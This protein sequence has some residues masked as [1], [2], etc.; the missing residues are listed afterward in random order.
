MAQA[1]KIHYKGEAGPWADTKGFTTFC[2]TVLDPDFPRS[3]IRKQKEW[4][5]NQ[6]VED[7]GDLA[8]NRLM[9]GDPEFLMRSQIYNVG[10][11][12]YDQEVATMIKLAYS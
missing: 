9:I 5:Y 8:Y 7:I 10:V 6:I 1:F 2:F 4:I 12:V 11:H 3:N